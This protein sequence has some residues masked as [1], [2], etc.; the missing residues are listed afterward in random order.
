MTVRLTETERKVADL[1]SK[2]LRPREIAERLGISINTVYKALSKARRALE[3]AEEPVDG[4]RYYAFS[5][6]VYMYNV[7]SQ[8][9]PISV[10]SSRAVLIHEVQDAVLKKLDEILAILKSSRPEPRAA[11][12]PP[13]READ[14]GNDGNGHLPEPLRKNIWI[15]LL[16]S[17]A[18]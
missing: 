17:K 9:Q 16:R 1:Y 6:S 8:A 18:V 14:L 12:A 2:G 7:F 5:A 13:A 11:K 15:S 3:L 4:Q 10:S